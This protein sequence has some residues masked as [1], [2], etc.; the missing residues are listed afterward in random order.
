M[1]STAVALNLVGTALGSFLAA[2]IVQ[3]V[4]KFTEWLPAESAGAE[5]LNHSRLD[6][7]YLMLA[8]L[9]AAN[10]CLFVPIATR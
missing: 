4:G 2:G 5:G 9:M 8:G 1:R 3:L 7:Y 6:L 10:I